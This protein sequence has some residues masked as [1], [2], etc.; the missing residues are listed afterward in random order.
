MELTSLISPWLANNPALLPDPAAQRW[1]WQGLWALVLASGVLALARPLPQL[2]RFGLGALVLGWT[3]L[4][5]VLS[6]AHWL[7]LMFQAPSLMSVAL[8]LGWVLGS[9]R[10]APG[11]TAL[12]LTGVLLGWVLLLDTL[13]GWQVSVYAWGFSS[14]ALAAVALFAAV[15]WV[16]AG[17][18]RASRRAAGLVAGVLL[19][20]VLSRW[21]T[22]NVWDALL[23]PWLWGVLQ[24]RL[25]VS[26]VR[27]WRAARRPAATRA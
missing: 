11:D 10:P 19:L 16:L 26:A 25:I 15:F 21:P 4:A 5:G 20:F 22:G 13:A 17:A 24:L 23:D 8:C 12:A 27:R 3:L 2:Y 18:N 1:A 14:A 6:P 7:G 9:R